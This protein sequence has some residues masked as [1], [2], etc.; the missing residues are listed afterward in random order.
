MSNVVERFL[1]YVSFDTGS[2]DDIEAIPSTEKQ[3]KLARELER[4]MKELGLSDVSVSENCYVYGYIPANA[5]NLPSL[6]FI[7]HIDTVSGVPCSDIL[8]RI[9]ERY[10][11]GDIYLN[12]EM[13]IDEATYPFLSKYIGQDLIVTDGRTLLGADDKA[14]V[15]EILTMAETLLSRPDIKHGRICIGFT[16]DEEVGHGADAFDVEGFGADFAYTVDGGELGEI[17][18]ENFNACT[19][20]IMVQGNSIH[21]GSAK[22]KMVNA[23]H[24]A[25]EFD[26]LLPAAQRP[27]HTEGYEGF[28]HLEGLSGSA[29]KLAMLYIIRDHDMAK[30]EEKKATMRR[31]AEFI[32]LRYGDGTLKL[33]LTDTYYNMREKI[34]PHMHII[35]TAKAAMEACGVTPNVLPI[36]GG[37]DGAR[38]SYMGLPCP[39][40]C[41]GGCNFHGQREFISVQS[42]EKVC[43]I[44]LKIVEL[45][46]AK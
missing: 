15:A 40:L 1:R 4:E 34:I 33:H 46:N 27:E 44:L 6:G 42:M 10:E 41:T 23:C 12:P 35:E 16:P 18:Y 39:N 36:R 43:E 21:P 13:S 5:E 20:K 31:A 19:A 11:G 30:F 38:L 32:N 17:E 28:Y 26:A 22:D 14:G 2:E 37:T 9:V 25:T 8:P 7:A 45:T 29:A 24:V 3:F